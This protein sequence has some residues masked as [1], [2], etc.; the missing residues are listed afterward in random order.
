MNEYAFTIDIYNS[1]MRRKITAAMKKYNRALLIM[2]K[3]FGYEEKIKSE[4]RMQGISSETIYENVDEISFIYRFVYVYLKKYKASIMEKYYGN[5]LKNLKQPPDI[6]LVIRGQSLTKKVMDQMKTLYPGAEYIMYQWDSV[7]NNKEILDITNYFDR[8]LTFDMKDA[9]KYGWKYRPLFYCSGAE[10]N[11]SRKY[12]LTFIGSLH[13]Q[14]IAIV[15][16]IHDITRQ[17]GLHEFT[18]LFTI[19]T[20]YL[21]QK[22]ILHNTDFANGKNEDIKYKSLSLVETNNIFAESNIVVDYTHPKQNGFTMRT[23]ESIGN[24]CKLITNNKN[25]LQADFY[26]SNNVY[27]YDPEN[28]TIP[29]QFLNEPFI[30]LPDEIYE[31]YSIKSWI[32]DILGIE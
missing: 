15:N 4:F 23:I 19:R 24:K 2:P 10:R 12:D 27:V 14:R 21:K 9:D 18:Y 20:H 29:D 16:K 30:E 13:S 5:K 1:Q 11:D 8:I 7:E 26:N 31:R 6:I 3:Y 32:K 22:C 17:K 28:F 25:V